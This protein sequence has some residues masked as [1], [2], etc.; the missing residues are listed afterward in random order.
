MGGSVGTSV[1]STGN[2]MVQSIF[3]MMRGTKGGAKYEWEM[4]CSNAMIQMEG[5]GECGR[6]L[7]SCAQCMHLI[8]PYILHA[9][10]S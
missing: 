6:Q 7:I 4:V 1:D 9:W 5:D 3:K 10:M 2:G 8:L